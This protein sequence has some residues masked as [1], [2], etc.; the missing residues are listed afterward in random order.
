M[1]RG[2]QNALMKAFG[3]TEH[4][5][6]VLSVED[7][8]PAFRRIRFH[9]PTMIDGRETPTASFI[10]L[11]A[12]DPDGSDKV[13][14]RG[15]TL[16]DPD[17]ESGEVSFDFVLHQPA[18]PAASW[19]MAARPGDTITASYISYTKFDPPEPEPDGYLLIGD[20]S[21]IPAINSILEILGR[22]A[23]VVV[24]LQEVSAG[25]RSIPVTA[26][27]NARVEWVLQSTPEAIAGAIPHRDWSNWHAWLAGEAGMVKEVRARLNKQHDFPLADI[28]HRAYWVRG[29]AMRLR[30][31]H[32]AEEAEPAVDA[33]VADQAGRVTEP[34]T[35]EPAPAAGR[36]RSQRG[37]ELLAPL[38]WKLRAAGL[39]QGLISLMRLAPFV[40]LAEIGRK[41][42]SGEAG[43]SAYQPLVI[44][45]LALYGAATLFASMLLLWLHV[46]DAD[47]GRDLR[48]TVIDKLGRLPLGWYTE[49]NAASVRQSVQEDAGRLHY[50]V[51]HAVPDA[52]AG[53][54]T[55]V[56]VI[57]YLFTVDA[58]LAAMLFLPIIAFI[59]LFSHMMRGN[60]DNLARVADWTKKANAAAGAFVDAL[61]V[62]RVFGGNGRDLRAVLDGQAMFL[63]GWQRPMAGRKVLSQLAIQPPTFL[64]L[65]VA[66]GMW[67][68][69]T[70]GMTPAD[71]LPFIFLGTAFG[72]QI[73][74]VAYGLVPLREG[75]LA[76]RRIGVLLEEKELD[77]HSSNV[78]L[79][80]GPLTLRYRD[81]SFGYRPG[82]PV[83]K[84]ISFELKPGTMTA[85]IG[86]SGAG[87]STLAALPGRFHDVTE[88][89]ITLSA[90]STEID[91]RDLSPEVLNKR[92]GFVFQDVCFIRASVRDNIALS[93]PGASD[94][95]ID[96]A[97]RAAN[98]HDRIARLPRGYDSVIGE[99][100][101]LSGGEAQR[102]SIARVLLANPPI[103]VLDE[104][105]A[106][107][108]PESEHLVQ[109]AVA[110]LTRD[111]TVLVVAHRLHTITRADTIV[112]MKDG[113]IVQSGRHESL[114]A[115]PG[116][117]R[118]L[119]HAG[120][121]VAA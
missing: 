86:P 13:H 32:G 19:A 22:E 25:D 101:Y 55:P 74:A 28:Q 71:I 59:F 53:V 29:K 98:I 65:I 92:I 95:E 42:L 64:L 14:Q 36:W 77:R 85:L 103:L 3:A 91:I 81:V 39:L 51:T 33:K 87:K 54:V 110:A 82:K 58:G 26:H 62:V 90:G 57:L 56:A 109:Q 30:K 24:L 117:Y 27:P 88:G 111:R 45:T 23:R 47:F 11:W 70:G 100:A 79:P 2:F 48:R 76:A 67:R 66:G 96:A 21:A 89:A 116:L 112:V 41:L 69:G 119:W 61:A 20:P 99:D 15:Y 46:V 16:I 1:A 73:M 8:T 49:R 38:R 17:P 68:I 108:D 97:A 105:T 94:T 37:L 12:P 5:M 34:P 80:D 31:D 102:L 40:L 50:M 114:V 63:N 44:A 93:R 84:R 83:L 115:T 10:R 120:E 107:S 4:I 7:L 118:D 78:D 52:V 104:A 106:F 18:G 113:S 6:T 60:G 9:A 121:E 43:W 75:R 72:A 35:P